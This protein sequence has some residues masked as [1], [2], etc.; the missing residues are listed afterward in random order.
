MVA[1]MLWLSCFVGLIACSLVQGKRISQLK[2]EEYVNQTMTS[3]S[4]ISLILDPT[5]IE[6]TSYNCSKTIDLI[7][8]GEDAKSG[9]FPHQVLLG[10]KTNHTGVYRFD[11]GGTVISDRYVLTAAHCASKGNN[12]NP[13]PEIVRFAELDLTIDE[14]EF[15]I[16][17]EKITRHPAHRFRSSYH[18]IALVRLKEHLRFSA[19]VRPA[20][21]WVDVDTSPSPVIAT[22]FGQLDVADER[23]SNTLRK[24]QLDVQDLSGC[25]NQFL[26]T[27]NFPN[28]MTDN[29]LCIGS[30]RGGKDTCQG[31]SGGPIQVL[32]NPKWCI[33]HVLGV[34]SAGSACGTMVPAVYTKV[35][36]YIDW[37]EGIVWGSG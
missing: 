15:D 6:F 20:C 33:Y 27:R 19:V 23:G 29:Q 11:C 28:G 1:R 13:A 37:I 12:M 25:N 5:P 17:I 14:D 32:A 8:G 2:C 3:V 18:D 24:V 26:G 16:E 10:W 21:L 31:D 34:T 22:G 35:A 9:E 30:S 36:S 4:V 7:V